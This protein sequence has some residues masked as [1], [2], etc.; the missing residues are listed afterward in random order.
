MRS[1][2]WVALLLNCWLVLSACGATA[3][4]GPA[5]PG[6]A[7]TPRVN[8]TP[9]TVLAH[10]SAAVSLEATGADLASALNVEPQAVR[11]RIQTS[12]CSVCTGQED[13]KLHTAEGLSLDEAATYLVPGDGFYLFVGDFTCYYRYDGATYTPR[14]CQYAPA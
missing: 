14:T 5:I 10:L 4:T 11:V 3:A 12:T 9:D 6:A 7:K 1:R 8:A 2:L 13:P